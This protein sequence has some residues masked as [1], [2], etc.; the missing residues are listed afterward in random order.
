MLL[1]AIP[2]TVLPFYGIK[3]YPSSVYGVTVSFL[4]TVFF[5]IRYDTFG[6]S[7]LTVSDYL[8]NQIDYGVMVYDYQ[9]TH[10]FSDFYA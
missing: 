7:K 5:S 9:R 4:M 8:F 3:S 2:D 6:I 1:S 10:I